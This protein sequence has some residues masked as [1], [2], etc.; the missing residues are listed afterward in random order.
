MNILFLVLCIV[1]EI[2]FIIF[3]F[4][5]QPEKKS[6]LRN[7][8][9]LTGVELLVL[10]L[11]S[12]LPS[13]DLSFRFKAVLILFIVKLIINL[14]FFLIKRKHGEDAKNKFSVIFSGLVSM[15]LI[16]GSLVPSFFFTAYDGG[17]PTGAYKVATANAILVDST[18]KE[19]FE[20]DGSNREVPVYFYYPE[21]YSQTDSFPLVLF[22]HGAFGY[23]Q[24]NTSTYM[25]L[26]S[27]GYVVVSLDHPYHSFFTTD[28]D[29]KTITVNP[30]FIQSVM[31]INQQDTPEEEIHKLSS[32]WLVLRDADMNFALDTICLAAK[33]NSLSADWFVTSKEGTKIEGILSHINCDRI[34]LM[35]HSLGGASS[36]SLGRT[37]NDIDAVIDFDGT[38]LGEIIDY[39]ND[40]YV[41]NEEP[42]PIPLLVFDNE[43][44]HIESAILED[45]GILYV[46]NVVME[47]AAEG[48][49]TYFKGAGH[50]NYTDLPLF[51]PTL[52]GMLGTGDV[53]AAYCIDTMNQITLNFFDCYLK[54]GAA[55]EVK[56]CY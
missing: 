6:W 55:F 5:K 23:Y 21:N 41:I 45:Q 40:T 56:D 22:S 43:E 12:V 17:I 3:T 42:Y 52:A 48:F 4:T 50:M 31:Y 34:G 9:F 37:R 36:V 1:F 10:L 14:L 13:V 53:D 26:A 49:E 47:H 25:E 15:L 2:S 51:S 29:G 39:V 33:T 27:H 30:E 7:R 54:G 11:L 35:G 20:Q 24:S 44:H 19:A 28:T 18:R 32:D 38:M 16:L 8:L 46:N